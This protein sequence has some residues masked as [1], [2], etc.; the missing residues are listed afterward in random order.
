MIYPSKYH[1][2]REAIL[3]LNTWKRRGLLVEAL[4][5]TDVQKAEMP[6]MKVPQVSSLFQSLI[7]YG[8]CSIDI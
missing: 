4:T 2:A 5:S 7:N 6:F 1:T 3:E 8:I